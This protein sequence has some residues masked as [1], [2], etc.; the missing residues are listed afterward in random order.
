MKSLNGTLAKAINKQ[1]GR[2]GQVIATRYDLH[3]LRT[4]AEVRNAVRYVLRNA[5]RHG[6]Y[7]AWPDQMN[8]PRPDPLSTAAWFPHWAERE[9][10]LAP[11]QVPAS[12]V[13]PAECYLMQLAF[14]G[15][16][17]SF[18]EPVRCTATPRRRPSTRTHSTRA[19]GLRAVQRPP[20]RVS[21]RG[22]GGSG[23][24]W[25]YSIVG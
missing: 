3:V 1:L 8:A 17:L 9:L 5:E 11:T 7:E 24:P 20:N 22:R 25:S 15:A 6:L 12:V 14:Q 13:R 4:R 2:K 21:V 10:L 19:R 23:G 16:P 18:A